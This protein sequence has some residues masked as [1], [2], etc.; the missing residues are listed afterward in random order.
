MQYWTTRWLS[1]A[2]CILAE[3]PL[4]MSTSCFKRCGI[5]VSL[6]S[7][8]EGLWKL[9][10]LDSRCYVYIGKIAEEFAWP[11][12][13]HF[14]LFRLWRIS[15]KS[16]T[17]T[18]H[19]HA[20]I[21]TPKM[22]FLRFWNLHSSHSPDTSLSSNGCCQRLPEPGLYHCQTRPFYRPSKRFVSS[23]GYP[24]CGGCQIG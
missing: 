9:K 19:F 24:W 17:A 4:P 21:V 15:I 13:R 3:T 11:N 18:Q 22:T 20:N 5:A 2:N 1:T 14:R 7:N 6:F 23:M 16:G 8:D 10:I 12:L